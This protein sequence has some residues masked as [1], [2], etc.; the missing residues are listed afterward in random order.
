[1]TEKK[2]NQL[3][4]DVFSGLNSQNNWVTTF[5]LVQ[6]KPVVASGVKKVAACS[7]EQSTFGQLL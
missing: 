4:N 3:F 2:K 5:M 6:L 7:C 1:M